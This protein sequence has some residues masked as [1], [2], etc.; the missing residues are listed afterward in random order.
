V[1]ELGLDG[2]VA[3]LPGHGTAGGPTAQAK[4]FFGEGAK[5]MLDL[6]KD[7]LKHDFSL[8][9]AVQKALSALAGVIAGEL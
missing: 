4:V 7:T 2:A 8:L 1:L 6:D 9:T 3:D 5:K